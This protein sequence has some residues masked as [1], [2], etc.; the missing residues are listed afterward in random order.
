MQRLLAGA[1]VALCGTFVCCWQAAAEQPQ[2]QQREAPE[3][4]EGTTWLNGGPV[5]LA[6]LRGRV[7]VV[8]FHA[9]GCVNCVRNYPWYQKWHRELGPKGV[10]L[11]GIHTPETEAEKDVDKLREHLRT[12]GLEF[13][14][15]VDNE[16]ANWK[17]WENRL[18]PCVYLIDKRGIVRWR[19]DGEFK[20]GPYDGDKTLRRKLEQLLREEGPVV[21]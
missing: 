16:G 19:W 21:P 8:H 14:V 3:F 10:V 2:A 7:V 5:K 20:Y 9:R 15:A 4:S 12:H 11:I 17:A 18:W 1:L 13:P 6:D